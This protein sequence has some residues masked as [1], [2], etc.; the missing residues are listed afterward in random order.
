MSSYLGQ[1]PFGQTVRTTTSITATAGQ[2]TVYPTGGY[3]IG[4]IDVWV[5][6]ARLTEVLDFTADNGVSVVFNPALDPDDQVEIV[7][8]GSFSFADAI[9]RSGD[10]VGGTLYTRDLVPYANVTYSLGTA[11]NRFKDLYLSGS[12]LYLGNI[13]VG[14]TNTGITI[15]NSSASLGTL[16]TTDDVANAVNTAFSAIVPGSSTEAGILKVVDSTSNTSTTVAAA[17]RSV[18]TAYNTAVTAQNMAA[19]AYANAVATAN[20][21]ADT[22]YANAVIQ[23]G[24]VAATAYANAIARSASN[25]YVNTTF[26]PKADPTLTGAVTISGTLATGNTIV[27]GRASVTGDVQIDGN[28]IVAGNTITV[29]SSTLSVT[30]NMLYMNNGVSANVTSATG[31][32]SVVT[33]VANNNYS[34][35]WDVGV[36]GVTP[37]SFNGSYTNILTANATHFT[38]ISTNVDVYVSGGIARGKSEANPDVGFAAGYNDGTYHHAGFFRDAT[39]GVWKV[40]DNYAPEPD[41]SVYIDTSNTTFRIA[42]FQANV[43]SAASL[44][45]TGTVSAN[46]ISV[47]NVA[48]TQTNL[49]V[50]PAGTAFLNALIY[51]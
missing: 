16:A 44:N 17:A 9:R 38:V 24:S 20:T 39:D 34:A 40:Y 29:S 5:N 49:Q 19:N 2:T 42:D 48:Q 11:N 31:N 36:T 18:T 27:T 43:V 15:A 35:G 12:T 8:Y 22:A 3:T 45:T 1:S 30:D 4:Y 33:F 7:A 6:G 26:A 21:Y 37:S 28:L 25:S 41:A 32:G 47:S 51:G 10:T 46:A 13:L 14:T 50:D 23:A